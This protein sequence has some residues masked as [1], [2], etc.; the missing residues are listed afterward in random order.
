MEITCMDGEM[1]IGNLKVKRSIL[2]TI[3]V[4]FF[5]R[6]QKSRFDYLPSFT[7]VLSDISPTIISDTASQS[8]KCDAEDTENF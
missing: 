3:S 8:V 4:R 1:K 5:C 7:G 2:P 6:L